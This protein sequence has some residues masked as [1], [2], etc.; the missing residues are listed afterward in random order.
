M[1][2]TFP[3]YS[4]ARWIRQNNRVYYERRWNED[5]FREER[6]RTE[7]VTAYKECTTASTKTAAFNAF[8]NQRELPTFTVYYSGEAVNSYS[9]TF[10][11]FSCDDVD[12]YDYGTGVSRVTVTASDGD[13]VWYYKDE[14]GNWTEA[15]EEEE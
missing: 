14:D 13:D 4:N 12:V 9:D 6:K 2:N 11:Q 3:S 5:E 1:A 7:T 10:E 15:T 8:F